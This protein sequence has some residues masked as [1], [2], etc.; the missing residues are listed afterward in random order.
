MSQEI[1]QAEKLAV[2]RNDL[3]KR[4]AT[5]PFE[6]AIQNEA[7]RDYPADIAPMKY[8]RLPETNSQNQWIDGKEPP[9]GYDINA[10]PDVTKVE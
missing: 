2:L 1:S 9:L 10:V 8:P 5:T 4:K 6:L 7:K 3:V